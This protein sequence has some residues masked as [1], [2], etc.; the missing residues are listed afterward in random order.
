M[1][2]ALDDAKVYVGYMIIFEFVKSENMLRFIFAF[3]ALHYLKTHTQTVT[4]S[5]DFILQ[6]FPGY[7][8]EAW[9][10]FRRYNGIPVLSCA[11]EDLAKVS[12]S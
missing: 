8:F 5:V 12:L 6:A 3:S 9:G 7:T 11:E 4:G 1:L 2:F 10:H